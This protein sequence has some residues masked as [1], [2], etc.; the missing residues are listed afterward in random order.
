[1]QMQL[2][3][4]ASHLSAEYQGE[5]VSFSQVSTD[6]RTL[7]HGAL[8]VALQGEN[9]DGHDCLQQAQD[10]GAVAAMVSRLPESSLPLLKVNDTRTGLGELAS[11]WRDQFAI[12]LAAVTG[13]N[14]K[15]SVKEM[16]AAIMRQSGEVLST[17]GNLNN[18]IGVPLTLLRL[19]DQH[20]AAVIEMGANHAG[21]IQY[22]CSLARPSIA[23]ITNAAAAHLEGFGSLEGV[24]RAKGEIFSSLPDDGIVVMNAD[25]HYAPLWEGLA[26]DRKV[27][28]FGL[29][30]PADVSAKWKAADDAVSLDLST[31]QGRC[32]V[33]LPLPGRHNVMNALA[34]VAVSQAM[35]ADLKM[36]KA[37]LESIKP[38]GGRLQTLRGLPGMMLLNDT[39]NAN[40]DSFAVAVD[41]LTGMKGDHKWLVLGDMGE[42]GK[43]AAR[44]HADC[45][46]I[47]R[48]HGVQRLYA[49]GDLCREAVKGF[50][51]SGYWF[52]SKDDLIQQIRK[53]WQGD[54]ALLVK[55]SRAMHMEE[56]VNNLQAG[57]Q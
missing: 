9:F 26:G 57:E 4:A 29:Q 13:S 38:V 44:L 16:I 30:K 15:T 7:Q 43:D 17:F 37:G 1:M 11:L 10:A 42:L 32:A 36:I 14:G 45:V 54:G 2:S 19:Q 12:P 35:G 48:E 51:E 8:F 34:A 49:T 28:R 18:D 20:R 46:R 53:D 6:T 31:P 33:R 40:P 47:A 41:V 56:I 24:A 23:V 5:D 3:Y 39:Y 55:G 52:S 25:D 21:E 22:L 50:G 27:I